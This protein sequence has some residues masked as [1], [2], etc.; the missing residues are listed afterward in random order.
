VNAE[1]STRRTSGRNLVIRT[2]RHPD[3]GRATLSETDRRLLDVLCRHRV[4]RQDQLARLL[5]DVRERTLRYRTRRLHDLGLMG[6]T[7]PYRERGSAPNHH[8]PTRRADC[9]M[10]GDSLPRGGERR[11]PNPLFLAHGAGLT[12]LYVTLATNGPGAGL[13][14]VEYRL[15]ADAREPFKHLG[16]PRTLTPD[17]FVVLADEH[18]RELEAFVELDLGTM[19]HARLRKKANLYAAYTA[20]GVWRERHL[21]LPALLFLTTTPARAHRFLAALHVELAKNR[22]HYSQYKLAAGAGAVALEPARLLDGA[23]LVDR[24]GEESLTLRDVLEVAR[25][26]YDRIERANRKREET[27]ERKRAQLRE[28]PAAARK[29]LQRF[30]DSHAAYLEELGAA[31]RRAVEILIASTDP[32]AEQEQAALDALVADLENVLVQLGGWAPSP[33]STV[34]RA[35]DALVP[36]YRERHQRLIEELTARYGEGPSIRW[37]RKTLQN[38]KL[39]DHRSAE[40]LPDKASRDAQARDEQDRR[41]LAYLEWREQAAQSL[42]RKAGPMARLTRSREDFYPQIDHEQL[43]ECKRCK[44]TI[45]PQPDQEQTAAGRR[46]AECP[47]CP[48][49][50]GARIVL[51]YADT[52]GWQ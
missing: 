52:E 27:Q 33:D 29:A 17:A 40:G 42:L 2:R 25:A 36:F 44:Q 12:E 43:R 41:R 50:G 9:M 38:E 35:V 37:A 16:K 4:V 18:Q 39:L 49:I 24:D 6:R 45:Y 32:P 20:A 51:P 10:N 3:L 11:G 14:L 30:Q 7:R 48:D 34:R 47:F 19:S 26:P 21:F 22:R 15:E 23:C 28:D 13:A 31:G 1:D 5:P 46:S 8:W